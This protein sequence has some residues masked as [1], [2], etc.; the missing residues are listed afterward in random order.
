MIPVDLAL[1]F[2]LL[3]VISNYRVHHSVLYP[4]FIFCSMWL[5]DLVVVRSGLVDLDPVHGNTLAIVAAGAVAF[6]VGGLLANFAPRGML[7]MH[8]FPSRPGWTPELL[9]KTVMIVLLCGLP[10]MLYHTWQLGRS[11]G[12]GLN[13]LMQARL[14]I[15]EEVRDEQPSVAIVL[16]STFTSIATLASLLMATEKRDRT[17]WVV[18]AVAFIGCILGTGRVELLGL[19]SGLSTI[20]LLRKREESFVTALRFLRW[21]IALFVTLYIGLIFTNKYTE[22]M[23]GGVTG[24]ASVIV[25]SYIACPLAAFDRVVQQPADFMMASSHTFKFPLRIAAALHL[26]NY[27]S[28]PL[29]DSFVLVPFPTNV[30]TVFKYYFLELGLAG[31]LLILFIIGMFHSLLYLKAKQGGRFSTYLF[32]F[33]IF[34]VLMVI[35]DDWY[36]NIGAYFRVVIL[37]VIY[38]A[39]G[40]VSLHMFSVNRQRVSS[41]TDISLN[42]RVSKT[43]TRE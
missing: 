31:T 7:Q 39:V 6:S 15:V 17:F 5:L 23:T 9:R 19:I 42:C 18:T 20:L 14:A 3:L 36:Y 33:S 8:L 27:T 43:R 22:T 10:L 32:A 16:A 4:P 41:A 40:S 2:F 38:F 34:S 26:T 11:Q 37:G 28:P 12:S 29:L 1:V 13:I 21:P 35:F 24:I 30:Y 25:L